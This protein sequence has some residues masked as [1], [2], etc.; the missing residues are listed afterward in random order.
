[1]KNT[2]TNYTINAAAKEIII[3]KKFEKAANVIGSNEYKDL[4]TLM[5]D[6]PEFSIKVKEIKKKKGKKTYNGL[7]IKEMRRFIESRSENELILFDKVV[8]IAKQK[9][10]SYAITKKWF[11]NKYKEDYDKEL[12]ALKLGMEIDEIENELEDIEMDEV[13]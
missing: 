13:A 3:T 8:E 9:K 4:V 5:K 7:T 1:M 10:G 6:F 11:L 2:T 12:E